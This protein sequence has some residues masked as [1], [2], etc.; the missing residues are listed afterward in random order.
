MRLFLRRSLWGLLILISL[1]LLIV[2]G[3]ILFAGSERG[4]QLIWQTLSDQ[5]PDTIKSGELEGRLADEIQLKNLNIELPDLTV[6]AD[7]ITLDWQPLKLLKRALVIDNLLLDNIAID[8]RRAPTPPAD[9]PVVLSDIELPIRIALNNFKLN[10]LAY[11][12]PDM[13]EPI[14]VNRL[15]FAIDTKQNTINLSDLDFV[16]PQIKA[17]LNGQVKPTGAYP[18]DINLNWQITLPDQPVLTGT[19][20]IQGDLKNLHIEQSLTAPTEVNIAADVTD[21]LGQL[22]WQATVDG[23]AIDVQAF[24]PASPE[25]KVGIHLQS[26]GVL[27]EAY[28]AGEIDVA[29]NDVSDWH[30]TLDLLVRNQAELA[31]NQ[32]NITSPT[33]PSTLS[34][35][36]QVALKENAPMDVTGE[37]KA[38]QWPLR[39]D[40]AELIARSDQGQ[41]QLLGELDDYTITLSSS[42]WTPQTETLPI[43]LD[44][45]GSLSQFTLHKFNTKFSNGDINAQG[46]VDW[47]KQPL[48][49]ALNGGWQGLLIKLPDQSIASPQ[50]DFKIAGDLEKYDLSFTTRVEGD[51][52]PP[53]DLRL[54][55]TGSAESFSLKTLHAN[56]L[57]GQLDLTGDVAWSPQIKWD[58]TLSGDGIN[59]QALAAE[60]PGKLSINSHI[61]GQMTETGPNATINQTKINGELRGYQLSSEV[62]ADITNALTKINAFFLRSGQ[63]QIMSKGTINPNDNSLDLSVK[64]DSP[65]LAELYPDAKGTL[66]VHGYVKGALNGPNV[67]A[68][69]NGQNIAIAGS[70]I[71][72]L[73]ADIQIDLAPLMQAAES[74]QPKPAAGSINGGFA[75]KAD[76]S[77]IRSG[78]TRISQANLNG[79]GTL[80][81]HTITADV[82]SDQGNVSTSLAGGLNKNRWQGFLNTL[83]LDETVV[84]RWELNKPARLDLSAEQASVDSLCLTQAD[85]SLCANAKYAAKTGWQANTELSTLRLKRF[86]QF[87]PPGVNAEGEVNATAAFSGKGSQVRGNMDLNTSAGHLYAE[88]ATEA[89]TPEL[90]FDPSSVKLTLDDKGAAVD[91]ALNISEP[92]RSPIIA[93]VKTS[94]FELGN[95]DMAQLPIDGK[96]TSNIADLSFLETFTTELEEV[97]AALDIDLNI[98]GTVSQPK[99]A[100]HTDLTGSLLVPRAGLALQDIKLNAVSDVQNKINLNGQITSGEGKLNLAGTVQPFDEG[101]PANFTIKG[102]RFEVINLPEAHVYASPDLAIVS[103]DKIVNI[104][105]KVVIPEAQIEP[106]AV[107]SAVPVSDDVIIVQEQVETK[108]TAVKVKADV[109]IELGDNIHVEAS[110]FTGRIA[111]AIKVKSRP[112]KVLT[113]VGE[114]NILDGK[115]AAYGQALDISKGRIIFAGGPIDSPSLDFEA[116]RLSNG[117]TAGVSVSG[118]PDSPELTL[119]SDPTMNQDSILSYLLLGRPLNEAS[120][121]DSDML[122]GAATSLGFKGG[123]LL[124]ENLGN[125][126]GLDDFSIG[127][128]TKESAAL[129][130]G[131]YL[132]PKLYVSYGVGLFEPVTQL[133]MRYDLGRRWSLEAVSGTHSGMDFL[134]KYEK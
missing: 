79:N 1:L 92:T 132:T 61:V 62:N 53:G 102:E 12:K 85:T 114:L 3:T 103:A 42:V 83:A 101:M 71:G 25:M 73:L 9:E 110:G 78:G 50:G 76:I 111:G 119:F 81:K 46:N 87:M 27:N 82:Q 24:A 99:I 118:T 49:F 47:S 41:F 2:V 95:T 5:L 28:L 40:A 70:S 6:S 126:L 8:D 69:A 130:L 11:N 20:V 51:Q 60:W 56:L 120:S 66:S 68:K 97:K 80:G 134:Y 39:G 13:A 131:K 96:V 33:L 91:I 89:D 4:T 10:E 43:Q 107:E 98:A 34:L 129:Q 94:P 117:V 21:I 57:E 48:S 74:S 84:G 38:L 14:T 45:A 116:T 67:D 65:N 121:S 32:I 36:G 35:Q 17:G 22:G 58:M 100:G 128:S 63:S 19:G 31:I 29:S 108:A 7:Q 105:G 125:S 133:K 72:K 88:G 30:T 112:K 124:T 23:D 122:L 86:A 52:I 90:H 16:M 15:A 77:D 26:H 109:T 54:V 123:E 37:W 44:G 113:G 93:T 104:T 75:I 127:G 115:F 59:P 106:V 55:G 18:T 64:L